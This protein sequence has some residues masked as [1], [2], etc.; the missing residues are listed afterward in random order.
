MNIAVGNR[1]RVRMRKYIGNKEEIISG[2]VKGKY[3]DFFVID[4]G[5]YKVTVHKREIA[6]GESEFLAVRA[7]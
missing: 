1:V 3:R 4:T 6:C 7:K 2:V 5:K